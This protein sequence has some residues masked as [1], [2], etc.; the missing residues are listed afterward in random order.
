[1]AR[2]AGKR[3]EPRRK[4][5][6]KTSSGRR[7]LPTVDDQ[8]QSRMNPKVLLGIGGA[9]I[10]ILFI[11]AVAVGLS[12]ETDVEDAMPQNVDVQID[13]DALP[14]FDAA[15][16]VDPAVGQTAPSVTTVLLDGSPASLTYDGTPKALLFL[17]H[18]CHFCQAEVPALQA[19][20]DANGLPDGVEL[21]SVATSNDPTRTNYPASSWLEREGWTAPVLVDDAASSIGRSFG[22][23]AFPY[24]VFVNG[25]GEVVGRISGQQQ[26]ETVIAA[27]E[28]MVAAR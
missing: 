6:A 19:Y 16:D 14:P 2:T 22:L 12:N 9:L 5:E 10:L 27:M 25:R 11:V 28:S 20:I 17:A 3:Q 1:M 15:T 24:Y 23:S 7:P 21:V 18:W 4:V 13:G 26:P 8:Q